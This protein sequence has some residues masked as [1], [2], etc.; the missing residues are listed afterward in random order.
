MFMRG[1]ERFLGAQGLEMRLTT[2]ALFQSIFRPGE[3]EHL[4]LAS[5]RRLFDRFFETHVEAIEAAPGAADGLARLAR[6]A[7]IVILTNAPEHSREARARWLAESGF[8][9]PLIVGAGPK[10]PAVAAL[11]ART[12][13]P[14]AF[15]DDLLSNLESVAQAAPAVHRFQ[16]VADER[17][18][19]L[20][21]ADLARHRR[22]D[23]WPDL[24]EAIA[25]AVGI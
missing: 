7:S 15:V 12:T 11:A 3:A 24:S 17:L 21:F 20:A 16:M 1:F 2:Y 19:A 5:G 9:Y 10:G 6:S 18:R 4:D 25:Q 14:A 22:I 23:D 13:R 8:P